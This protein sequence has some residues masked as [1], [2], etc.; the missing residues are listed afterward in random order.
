[1]LAGVN[2]T[3]L[4]S[5][6]LIYLLIYEA[7]EH[8]SFQKD[9]GYIIQM[10]SFRISEHT[11]NQLLTISYDDGPIELVCLKSVTEFKSDKHTSNLIEM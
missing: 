10:K 5:K 4:Q 8:S 7:T 9:H 2:S 6:I 3:S 11:T 1:M